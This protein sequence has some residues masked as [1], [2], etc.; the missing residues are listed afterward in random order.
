MHRLEVNCHT[1]RW[2]LRIHARGCLSGSLEPFT[3]VTAASLAP[4]EFKLVAESAIQF[5]SCVRA[6]HI[7][8]AFLPAFDDQ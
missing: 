3:S 2:I 8:R 1:I 6:R 4:S 7:E 5:S